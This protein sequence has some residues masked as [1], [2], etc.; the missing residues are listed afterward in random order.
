MIGMRGLGL[1]VQLSCR[2]GE[3]GAGQLEEKGRDLFHRP[4]VVVYTPTER[5]RQAS[6]QKHTLLRH[7]KKEK[8]KKGQKEGER[9]I[10]IFL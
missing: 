9:R 7:M 1:H 6:R 8:L 5:D 4:P 10:N 3:K 2:Q